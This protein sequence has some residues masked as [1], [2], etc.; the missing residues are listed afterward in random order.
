MAM[1]FK[2]VRIQGAELAE[3]TM[4]A[5]GIFSMC[6]QLVQNNVM[7]AED[8][9]L[10]HEIDDWFAHELPWPEPCRRREKVVC[11][12]KTENAD[13]MMRYIRPMMWLLEKYD[14]PYYVVYTNSPGEIVYEDEYQVAVKVPGTL[15]I[16]K[17]QDSWSEGL[18]LNDKG[19]VED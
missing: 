16:E 9:E 13:E 7:D 18:K 4:Y 8:A 11:F 2:Y 6:V 1:K 14:H 10:F 17:M 3:N 12:F 19:V 15:Q 5:K